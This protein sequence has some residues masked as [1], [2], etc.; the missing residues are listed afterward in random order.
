MSEARRS[1]EARL[2]VARA[3]ASAASGT[4]H[5][6]RVL[7]LAQAWSERGGRVR[8]L[9]ASAPDPLI[10]RIEAEGMG[11]DRLGDPAASAKD[12]SILRRALTRHSSAMAVVDG[13]R[14]DHAYLEALG[15]AGDRVLFVD[16][17]GALPRYPIG[18]VLNQNLHADRR[19]YPADAECRFLLGT[20]YV[21]LR[22]E[23]SPDP[24]LRTISLTVR[25]VLVTF[26]GADPTGMTQRTLEALMRLPRAL[27]SGISVRVIVGAANRDADRLETAV[28]APGLDVKATV[29][30][31]VADMPAH[32]SWA[33]LAITSGGSTVWE[34]ARMGCPALVVETVPAEERLVSSLANADLF[35]RL[36]SVS[37]LNAETMADEI[38]AKIKDA[39]WRRQM[40]ARGMSLVDGRGAQRVVAA[41]NDG[42]MAQGRSK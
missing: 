38:A 3:D 17:M 39:A 7:A 30:R 22:R 2:L 28:A 16:D 32:M 25:H 4:G 18:Y 13:D 23:F 9:I 10:A 34:L 20:R 12:A 41:L 24:P 33:D 19:A 26:G 35:G 37:E 8:W 5:F 40:S 31:D 21:L 1:L 11:I 29:F 36:G 14:F 15:E 6:M 42:D 27:R